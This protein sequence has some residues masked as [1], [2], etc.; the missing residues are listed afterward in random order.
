MKQNHPSFNGTS[1]LERKDI[2]EWDNL[3]SSGI[4]KI[5]IIIEHEKSY[6]GFSGWKDFWEGEFELRPWMIEWY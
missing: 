2:N 5:N 6:F 1:V 3:D 4:V